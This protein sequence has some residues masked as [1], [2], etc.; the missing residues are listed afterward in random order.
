MTLAHPSVKLMINRWQNRLR[1]ITGDESINLSAISLNEK[2]VEL[3]DLINI[4]CKLTGFTLAELKRKDRHR[5]KVIARQLI[6]FYAYKLR[7]STLEAIGE[8][9]GG[10]DHTTVIHAR[11]T[12]ENLIAAKDPTIH[13]LI[14]LIESEI[15]NHETQPS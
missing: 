6:F 9:I 4:I 15:K 8:K 14:H 13:C 10:R 11:E 7:L 2:G 12:I 5:P 3:D 1:T